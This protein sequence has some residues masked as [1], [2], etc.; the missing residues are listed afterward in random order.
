MNS[1]T[2]L[3]CALHQWRSDKWRA[4]MLTLEPL[5]TSMY[6]RLQTGGGAEGRGQ[7]EAG[8]GFRG[9]LECSRSNDFPP[10]SL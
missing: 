5:F 4:Q 1:W 10:F 2:G 9:R 8:S 6:I 3:V 7:R